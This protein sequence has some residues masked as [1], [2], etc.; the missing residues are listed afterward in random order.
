MFPQ[1][2]FVF[3]CA[4][5]F[6]E[7]RG[8]SFTNIMHSTGNETWRKIIN[9]ANGTAALVCLHLFYKKTGKL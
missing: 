4:V 2:L 9:H 1:C 3:V 5:A 7:K 6:A 8:K